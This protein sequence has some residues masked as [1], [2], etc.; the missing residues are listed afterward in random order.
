MEDP[1]NFA[2]TLFPKEDEFK[3]INVDHAELF[4]CKDVGKH[5]KTGGGEMDP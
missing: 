3:D 5:L 4:V 2:T 1:Y